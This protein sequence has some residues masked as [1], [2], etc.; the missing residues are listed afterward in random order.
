MPGSVVLYLLC[1][2]IV[3]VAGLAGFGGLTLVSAQDRVGVTRD[4][5]A[6]VARVSLL[7]DVVQSVSA[8]VDIAAGL[9]AR[10]LTALAADEALSSASPAAVSAARQQTDQLLAELGR[11][12]STT[13]LAGRLR[14][15]LRA[16]RSNDPLPPRG[17][18]N[19][20]LTW[21]GRRSTTLIGSVAAASTAE[22]QTGL[23]VA[24]GRYGTLSP[25]LAHAVVQLNAATILATSGGRMAS[26]VA[27]FLAT[28]QTVAAAAGFRQTVAEFQAYATT[29]GPQL[30][31]A[32]GRQWAYLS[33][34]SEAQEVRTD[35]EALL[36]GELKPIGASNELD[37]IVKVQSLGLTTT[38]LQ[39]Q[40]N[41][42]LES[43]IRQA[44]AAAT[45]DRGQALARARL[46]LGVCAALVVLTFVLWLGIG[47]A[48]RLRLQRLAETAEHPQPGGAAPLRPA[49]AAGADHGRAGPQR[50]RDEHRARAGRRRAPGRR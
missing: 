48:I 50:R 34:S 49:W 17:N 43:A 20:V 35:A 42:L 5:Q 39:V 18:L 47:G 28:P 8:E 6:A 40:L 19:E 29:L 41:D 26:L 12:A 21:T 7:D 36:D 31:G 23:D 32:L 25:A 27:A 10:G 9:T 33:S 30:A 46:A 1:V 44:E 14:A 16:A 3:P 15:R 13:V 22:V 4:V 11:D 45:R 2:W 38:A 24:D 37:Q